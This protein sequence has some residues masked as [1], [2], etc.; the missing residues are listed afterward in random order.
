MLE[1]CE[2]RFEDIPLE[3]HVSSRRRVFF[4]YSFW[5]IA[6]YDETGLDKGFSEP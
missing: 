1:L 5:I 3:S 4:D 2:N 6:A